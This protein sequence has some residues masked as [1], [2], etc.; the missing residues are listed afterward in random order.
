MRMA[1]VL[2]DPKEL[3]TKEQH[4]QTEREREEKITQ[5]QELIRKS[6]TRTGSLWRWKVS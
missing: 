5:K 1:T 4:R 6:T 2:P 3:K